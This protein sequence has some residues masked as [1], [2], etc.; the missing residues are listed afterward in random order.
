MA[1]LFAQ[2]TLRQCRC[3][4]MWSPNACLSSQACSTRGLCAC[5]WLSWQPCC[6]GPQQA[7]SSNQLLQRHHRHHL[8]HCLGAA[9]A[10]VKLHGTWLCK[11]ASSTAIQPA[12]LP[13]PLQHAVSTD[14]R[15][16]T[17]ALNPTHKETNELG[18][19]AGAASCTSAGMRPWVP[20]SSWRDVGTGCGWRVHPRANRY[21]AFPGSLLHGVLPASCAFLSPQALLVRVLAGVWLGMSVPQPAMMACSMLQRRL[22][23]RAALRQL[24]HM[25]STRDALSAAFEVCRLQFRALHRHICRDHRPP[26]RSSLQ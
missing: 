14:R 4:S 18:P 13:P 9:A 20:P 19:G 12:L 26:A 22:C 11:A 23:H 7:R 17:L 15:W 10:D 21:V 16:L 3:A 6:A 24:H 5:T 2:A 25:P 1:V 8:G